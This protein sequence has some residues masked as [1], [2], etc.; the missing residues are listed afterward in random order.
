MRATGWRLMVPIVL[1]TTLNPLN[2]SMVAVA[3]VAFHQDFHVTLGTATWL[4][5]AFYLTGA[6]GQP[7]M[8]RLADLLGARRVFVA[9]LAVVVMVAVLAPLAPNFGWLVAARCVQALATS[10]AFPAGLGLVRAAAGGGRIPA[11]S[12]SLLSIAA[13]VSAALGPTVGGL[14][15]AAWGWQG[16]FLV[17]LPL[18]VAGIVLAL[19]F[20]PDPPPSD[21]SGGGL[22]SLD[23]PGVALFALTLT[24]LLAALIELGSPRGW[25]LLAVVPFAAVL[26]AVREL[27]C[28]T[29]FLD[30]RLLARNPAMIG[31]F[32]QFGAVT[33][34]FYSFFFGLPIWF[35]QV[36]G[37]DARA[38]GLLVLPITGLG[39]LM[40]PVAARLVG[41]SGP[42]LSL[43]IGSAFMLA[44]TLLL[45]SF[46]PATGVP[47]LLAVAVVLG[48][49][50]GFNNLGLQAALYEIT[51][52]ERISWAGGQFQTFRYIGATLSSAILGS[53][54]REG[55][56]T[57]GLHSV[58]YVL[59]AVAALVLVASAF[60][61]R[62]VQ[63][64]PRPAPVAP[65]G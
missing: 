32:V 59:A 57:A 63:S 51:P 12:L 41:R 13:S 24:P 14:V 52:V 7:L 50:N 11:H 25:L 15:L 35:E 1:G 58:A 26:L 64:P 43:V 53:V 3:L 5:S 47:L 6:V 42:R 61:R 38:A 18:A 40:T 65:A 54:F 37:F 8:G 39:V 44:G 19:G 17:N 48:V 27:R 10:T 46:G 16:I 34:M 31:V 2:S 22:A 23:L 55:A 36:R 56:S 33:F 4:V 20:L 62:G 28:A 30:L 60:T 49:P 21:P 9:G 29:P 45:L